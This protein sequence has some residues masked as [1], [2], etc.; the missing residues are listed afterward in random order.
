MNFPDRSRSAALATIFCLTIAACGSKSATEPQ[1]Q[2]DAAPTATLIPYDLSKVPN[3]LVPETEAFGLGL[4]EYETETD[5]KAAL[6]SVMLFPDPDTLP[7]D[8][9]FVKAYYSAAMQDVF[10][11]STMGIIYHIGDQTG[12][13]R[14]I[15]ILYLSQML[16]FVEP[17]EPHENTTLRGGKTAYAFKPPFREGLHSIQWKEECRIASVIADLPA[18]DVARIAEGLHY[19]GKSQDD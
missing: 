1:G 6:G 11:Q 5:A 10:T 19:P 3:C 7:P 2:P 9:V 15:S 8:A 17:R 14:S 12:G 4:R 13:E 18:E 16:P